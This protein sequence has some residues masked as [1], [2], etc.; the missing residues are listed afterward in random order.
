MKSHAQA[1]VLLPLAG[2]WELGCSS[3]PLSVGREVAGDAGASGVA[4]AAGASGVADARGSALVGASDAS[5]PVSTVDAGCAVG[6][7]SANTSVG[8]GMEGITVTPADDLPPPAPGAGVQIAT[9]DY[10]PNDPNASQ[11][12]VQPGQERYAFYFAVLP[13]TVPLKIGALQ[14]WM[15]SSNTDLIIRRLDDGADAA[16]APFPDGTVT[17]T[18]PMTGLGPL[19]FLTMTPQ[20]V[21]SLYM[22]QGVGFSVAAHNE[23]MVS[24]HF[25][26]QGCKPLN[27][28]VKLNLLF[29]QNVQYEAGLM[30]SFNVSINVPMGT[31][32]G[33]GTQTVNGSCQAPAGSKVF[34]ATTETYSHATSASIDDV[35]QGQA[36]EIVHTGTATSYPSHQEPGSGGDWLHPGVSLW[37]APAFLTVGAGDSFTYQCVY[38]NAQSTP[39]TVGETLSNEI[40]MGIVYYFPAGN[41][42][43][44]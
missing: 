17:T 35:S 27:P 30:V 26:N 32:A 23:I 21:I 20:A 9:P 2:L 15:N 29:A 12:I 37:R 7:A 44:Q 8:S 4:D 42:S 43:C 14:S 18:A 3:T 28:K 25:V 34:L 33:P 13:N 40:C 31:A 11:M 24:M 38:A 10:D 36:T 16:A 19:L 1:L 22:P 6:L 39:V 5:L 41:A